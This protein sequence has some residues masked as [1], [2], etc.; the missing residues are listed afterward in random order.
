MAIIGRARL[1]ARPMMVLDQKGQSL[2]GSRASS[3]LV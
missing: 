2:D 1:S 3:A